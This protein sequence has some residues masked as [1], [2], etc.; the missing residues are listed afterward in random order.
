MEFSQ[1][2]PDISSQGPPQFNNPN[3]GPPP[4]QQQYHMPFQSNYRPY[5]NHHGNR[6]Y[7]K[8]FNSYRGGQKGM[9]SANS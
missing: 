6:P 3:N 8:N 9:F 4:V 5:F 7:F 2:P 1:P